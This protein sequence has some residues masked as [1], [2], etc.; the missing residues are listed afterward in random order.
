MAALHHITTNCDQS[1][2]RVHQVIIYQICISAIHTQLLARATDRLVR[3]SRG[4]NLLCLGYRKVMM[5]TG[6]CCTT[7]EPAQTGAM[8]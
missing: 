4:A 2:V 1:I 8:S 3:T 5:C 6:H 7:G